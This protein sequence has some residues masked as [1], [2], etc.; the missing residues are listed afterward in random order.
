MRPRPSRSR[1]GA[2]LAVLAG[3]VAI[4]ALAGCATTAPARRVIAPE[5]QA[6]LAKLEA[7]QAGLTDLRTLGDLRIKRDGK[8]QRLSGV[9]L[10]RPPAGLRFEALT[11]FGVP[12]VLVAGDSQSVTVW[13]V[14]DN[15]AYILPATPSATQRWLGMSLGSED[16]VAIL[17]GRIRPI[18]N[19]LTVELLPADHIAPSLKLANEDGEQRI[20]LDPETGVVR[21][22]EWTG[23]RNPARV[24]YDEAPADGPPA[25]LTM[26]TLDGSLELVAKYRDPKMNTGFD[27]SLLVLKVPEH[28]RVQDFR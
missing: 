2:R 18:R 25:G 10:L 20:W 16:L 19:P 13:E 24:V 21:Q 12:V 11:S 1:L 17:S 7:R 22:V 28:V 4:T 26:N 3:L 5:A 8:T 6:A 23:G 14:L 27:P 15:R 9:L